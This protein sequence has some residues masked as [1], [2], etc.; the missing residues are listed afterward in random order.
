[1][2]K[3]KLLAILLC[4]AL[5]FAFTACGGKDN[6]GN[7]GGASGE[8][9]EYTGPTMAEEADTE[10]DESKAP[11]DDNKAYGDLSKEIKA[12][13]DKKFKYGK[14]SV[15][16]VGDTMA[17]DFFDWTVNSV[18]TEK[19][20]NGKSAGDGQKF[21]VINMTMKNTEDFA[22][23]TGNFEFLGLIGTGENGE[24]NTEDAFY[25][26]MLGDEFE[27]GAGESVTGDI[28]F[29]VSDSLKNFIVDYEEFYGD[30]ST[31][32]TFWFEFSL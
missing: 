10:V 29:K 32:N 20:L 7:G 23:T 24:I 9:E 4:I 1:M 21:I 30:G 19:K 5:L 15:G 14:L 31:G 27:L 6:G 2:K 25:D 18:K 12:D 22:Y 26:G 11:T 8:E 17:N 28:V 3:K 13:W 16:T